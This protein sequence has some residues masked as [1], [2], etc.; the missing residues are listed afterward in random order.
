MPNRPDLLALLVFI[1]ASV[2]GGAMVWQADRLSA[3]A[4]RQAATS[5]AAS[6]AL[7]VEQ[8]L[9]RSLSATYALAAAVRRDASFR[10]PR[11]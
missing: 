9:S 8:Q 3:T 1:G 2:T 11:P 10:A 5:M 4:H 6:V 7:S